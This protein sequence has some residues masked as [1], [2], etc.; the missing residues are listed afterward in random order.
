MGFTTDPGDGYFAPNRFAVIEA[1]GVY[2]WQHDR[3]GMRADGGIGSQQVLKGAPFQTEW[4][5]G[6]SL[7]RGWG[8]KGEL[9][10]VGTITNSAAATS[11]AGVRTEAFRY[12]A[13]GLSFSQGL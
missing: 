6:L 1:R 11:T 10:L 9:A 4:H 3:W 12:R 8:V 5:L 7:S 2:A 13:V